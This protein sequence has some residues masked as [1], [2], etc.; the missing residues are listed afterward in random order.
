[1]SLKEN[2]SCPQGAAPADPAGC[3]LKIEFDRILE[4]T[5]DLTLAFQM[6]CQKRSLCRECTLVA[7]CRFWADF[8]AQA[9]AAIRDVLCQWGR[10]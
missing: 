6:L 5:Q 10:L 4:L 1:M 8:D 2:V 3:P 7:S 9:Q